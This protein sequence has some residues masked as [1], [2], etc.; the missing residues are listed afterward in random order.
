MQGETKNLGQIAAIWVSSNAPDN[1]KLLWY[2]TTERIHK[3]YNASTGEW[4]TLN[5]Q[6]VTNST[7]SS[8]RATALDTG[9][10]VG[11]FYYLTDVGTLAIAITTTKVWYV[12]SHSNYVVNDLSAAI[13]AYVN[14]TNL[15]IDGTTG[16]WNNSTGKLEFSFSTITA[17]A[18]LQGEN[19]YVVMRRKNGANWSWVKSKISNLISAVSGNSITWNNG[20]Y[21]NF[22]T[23][24]NAI[25]NRAGGIVGYDKYNTDKET[26]NQSIINAAQG[27]QQILSEAKSYTDQETSASKIYRKNHSGTWVIA[28]N[29]PNIP[30]PTATLEQILQIL[31]SW[32]NVLQ[33]SNRIKIGSGFSSNGRSGNVNYTD[34]IRAAIEKL[35]YKIKNQSKADGIELPN[36]FNIDGRAGNFSASDTLNILIEKL[37]Y[38]AI[39]ETEMQN[40]TSGVVNVRDVLYLLQGFRLYLVDGNGNNN[41]ILGFKTDNTLLLSNAGKDTE[42][43]TSLFRLILG[44]YQISFTENGIS[45]PTGFNINGRNGD[46]SDSDTIDT[47]LEK[48]IKKTK[49]LADANNIK[50]PNDFDPG[51]YDGSLPTVDDDLT[52]AI[53]KLTLILGNR[54]NETWNSTFRDDDWT[55]LVSVGDDIGQFDSNGR[56]L[57]TATLEGALYLL[58]LWYKENMEQRYSQR[59]YSAWYSQGRGDGHHESSTTINVKSTENGINFS[60]PST[61]SFET[62][63]AY[64]ETLYDSTTN[65][66]VLIM[67]SLPSDF[68]DRIKASYDLNTPISTGIPVVCSGSQGILHMI[69]VQSSEGNTYL[70]FIPYFTFTYDIDSTITMQYDNTGQNVIPGHGS[71][72]VSGMNFNTSGEFGTSWLQGEEMVAITIPKFNF[73]LPC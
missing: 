41:T 34:T 72:F 42:I 18:S 13:Q 11:K 33:D 35:V 3:V 65:D 29:P 30:N 10:S 66:V 58:S 71:N 62:Y 55:G 4:V 40:L 57:Y 14:S 63:S 32:V 25:K 1:T 73:T 19:D 64:Q 26:I 47:L 28:N 53:G 60:L 2:D 17:A 68:I 39:H 37:I 6:I 38:R 22:T 20:L 27:N 45:L 44:S 51:D 48:L 9:L 23:A 54:Y 36:G 61:L 24:I 15:L 67:R 52:A 12:D 16:V 49:D 46:F 21:F 56:P 69:L 43:Q 8:L 59:A 7:L 5:P 50:L 31:V 70:K